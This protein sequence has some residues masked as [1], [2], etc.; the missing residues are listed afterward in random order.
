MTN[1]YNTYELLKELQAIITALNQ[2][3]NEY[4]GLRGPTGEA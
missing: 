3:S 1:V 4:A 2:A